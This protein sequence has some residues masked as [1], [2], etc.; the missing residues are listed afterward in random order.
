MLHLSHRK[1]PLEYG[2]EAAEDLLRVL[3]L[4]SLTVLTAKDEI[5]LVRMPIHSQVIIGIGRVP[6]KR[7]RHE[8]LR[9]GGAQHIAGIER[10]LGLK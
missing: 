2:F 3:L 4:P 10:K 1:E 6:E 5:T 8:S 7:L 9:H